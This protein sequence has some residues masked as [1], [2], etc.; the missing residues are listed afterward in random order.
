[1]FIKFGEIKNQE[2]NKILIEINRESK[3]NENL[4]E[5]LIYIFAMRIISYFND[6]NNKDVYK[7]KSKKIINFFKF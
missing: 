3:K 5:I 7:G 4:K 2:E 6:C 1:M